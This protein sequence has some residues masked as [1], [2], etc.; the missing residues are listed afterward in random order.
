MTD[1][2]LYRSIVG[3]LQYA[4]VTRPEISYS[5][6]KACQ[7]MSQPLES[8]WKVVKQIL[9][10]LGGSLQHGLHLVPSTQP[11]GLRGFCDANWAANVDDR[12]LTSGACVYL[13][14]NLVSWWSKKQPTVARSNTE[15]EYRSLADTAAEIMWLQSLLTEL[16]VPPVRPVIY[17]DNLSTVMLSHNLVLHSRTQHM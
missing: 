15:A 17:C 9:R 1:P 7:F 3:A 5:V 10:Y 11:L 2:S 16:Q 4:T 6:N 8:H 14:Q 12:W 13:G